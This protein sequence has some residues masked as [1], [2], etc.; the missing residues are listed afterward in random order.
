MRSRLFGLVAV[1]VAITCAG[2]ALGA[3]AA[4][5]GGAAPPACLADVDAK[6]AEL[7][8]ADEKRKEA[9]AAVVDCDGWI[10]QYRAEIAR[11]KSNPA[12]V[13]DLR[14][15][16]ELGERLQ[17]ALEARPQLEAARVSWEAEVKR[18]SAVVQ[19]AI[20][21]CAATKRDAAAK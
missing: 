21:A 3:E 10:A 14:R 12:G 5:D 4:T 2:V 18:L 11:E 16:H 7:E 17:S 19:K 15:L 6:M 20:T 8:A 13:V 9:I 1:V